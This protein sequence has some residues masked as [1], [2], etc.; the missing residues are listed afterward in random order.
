MRQSERLP[1]AATAQFT[2]A[3]PDSIPRELARSGNSGCTWRDQLGLVMTEGFGGAGGAGGGGG[4]GTITG[5]PV[6]SWRSS[7]FVGSTATV[8]GGG[9]AWVLICGSRT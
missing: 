4:P 8:T 2:L 7:F 9:G 3:E 1:L 6:Y 5:G